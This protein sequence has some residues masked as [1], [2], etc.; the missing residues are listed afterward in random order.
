MKCIAF[1]LVVLVTN[2]AGQDIF[3]IG[4]IDTGPGMV[5]TGPTMMPGLPLVTC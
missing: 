3:S 1:C 2:S 5:Y 4:I